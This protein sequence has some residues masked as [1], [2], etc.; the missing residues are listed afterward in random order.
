MR[1]PRYCS[2][3]RT[4]VIVLLWL[5][6]CPRYFFYFSIVSNVFIVVQALSPLLF[7]LSTFLV[8]PRSLAATRNLDPLPL[9][10]WILRA[11]AHSERLWHS[12]G[13]SGS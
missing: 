6:R 7:Y 10:C 4:V 12:A 2:Y 3:F 8:A 11:G 13:S 1:C 9:G 5:R